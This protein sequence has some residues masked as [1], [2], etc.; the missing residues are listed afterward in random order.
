MAK[1]VFGLLVASALFSSVF[2]WSIFDGHLQAIN[3]PILI[4]EVQVG[5]TDGQGVENTKAEFVELT[6][7]SAEVVDLTGWQVQYLSSSND[8]SGAPTSTL[9]TLT[10]SLSAGGRALL[11]HSGYT[12]NSQS[13]VVIGQDDTSSSGLLA[14]SAGHVR[15]TNG[16]TAIDCVAWGSAITITGCDKVSA[17]AP[18]GYSLQRPVVAGSYDKTLGALNLTPT[19]PLGGDLFVSTS[20]DPVVEPPSQPIC[21]NIELSEILPNPTGD[22]AAGEFIELY[23]PSKEPQGLYG[24]LLKLSNGKQYGF[25]QEAYL[26]P[27]EYKAFYYVT[28]NL[29]LSNSGGTVS[30]ITASQTLSTTYP[31]STDDQAWVYGNGLWYS[32]NVPTPDFAN[33]PVDTEPAVV[34]SETE[35]C[36]EGKYRNPDTNRCKNI[37]VT[38]A[39]ACALGYSRNP[40]TGRCNKV[41]TPAAATVCQKGYEKNP[42]TNHCRKTPTPAAAKTCPAGQQRNTET[43]RCRK[44]LATTKKIDSNGPLATITHNYR[45][46]VA[47]LTLCIGYAIYEYRHDLSNLWARLRRREV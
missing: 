19:S 45:V 12:V 8:G 28:T 16:I 47:V 30:L 9:A 33:Y 26:L 4:T 3:P 36:P 7:V 27:Q 42:T 35:A 5:F 40:T 1:R 14:K 17:S 37:E 39:T 6:N 46:I 2:C 11:L 24:C 43:N 22:D 18:V 21:D 44:V 25:G 38:T 10:G 31:N 20:T 29:Q 23:N 15:L 41:A 34:I 32:A 13:D